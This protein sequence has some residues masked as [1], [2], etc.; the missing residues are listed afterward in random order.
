MSE[1]QGTM[2]MFLNRA[3]QRILSDGNSKKLPRLRESCSTTLD[4]IQKIGVTPVNDTKEHLE[5]IDKVTNKLIITLKLACESK[6]PK[7][8]SQALDCLQ[9]LIAYG[10]IRPTIKDIEKPE[11]RL[12]DKVME[13]IGDCFDSP[14]DNVQLQIIKAFLSAVS[15]P[16]C[17]IHDQALMIAIRA[18]F[19][20]I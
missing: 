6:Q 17:E 18:C 5:Q 11:R 13:I 20:F 10:F 3:L 8:M 14:D 16:A 4:L 12:I 7:I 2:E 15:S 1:S 19:N 9:K